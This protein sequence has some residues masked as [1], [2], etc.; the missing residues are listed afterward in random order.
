[1]SRLS[2]DVYRSLRRL[3]VSTCA[4]QPQF[5]SAA[6]VNQLRSA[7]EA[8][9][10]LNDAR[11]AM[12]DVPPDSIVYQRFVGVVMREAMERQLTPQLP[13]QAETQTVAAEEGF[14][15]GEYEAEAGAIH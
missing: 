2:L 1:M 4:L 3:G 14:E 8:I 15:G 10:R 7:F 5:R 13:S 9:R 11:T 6:D 12:Q